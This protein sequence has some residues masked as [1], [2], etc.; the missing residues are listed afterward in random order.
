VTRIETD[1]AIIG[2]GPGGST[3]GAFIRK[4]NPK[5]RVSIFEREV[6]PRDH[7]GESQL[8][9]IGSILSELGVWD[10]IEQCGF[11]IKIGGTYR[12]GNS[13]DL[14]D[15]DFLPY[16]KFEDAP[17]PGKYEGQRTLTAFQVDRSI[18][19]KVLTDY[20]AELGCDIHFDFPIRKVETKGDAVTS[21]IGKDDV[22]IVAKYYVDATGHV[23][24]LRRALNVEV[25]EPS[26][27]KNIAVWDYWR[28][29][30]WAVSLGI[31]GT[32][33]QIL[34]LGYGWIWFIPIS[35][36][37]T[38]IGFVCP[39]DYYKKSGLS[40]EDLYA[41]AIGDEP[42]LRELISS[43][44]RENALATTKDW[45]FIAKRMSGPNWFLVG[46]SAGFADPI[47]S[48][49]LSLTHA[50]A[51]ELAFIILEAERG[52]NL[53]WMTGE[54]QRRNDRRIRQHIRF[55]DYWYSANSHFSDLKQYTSEIAKDAGLD[56]SAE[57]AF[58]W[59]G[60]GGFIE[61]DMGV[62][63]TALI[64][65]DQL[66]QISGKLSQEPAKSTLDG[67]NLFMLRLKD[68]EE[69]RIARFEDG[70]VRTI[71][72]FKKGERILPLHNLFGWV[73]QGLKHSPQLDKMM[74]YLAGEMT[75]AGY[76][77]DTKLQA[78]LCECLDA[79]IRD[80]WVTAKLTESAP[81]LR[82]EIP[83]E[84]AAIR[85]HVDE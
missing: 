18:Y 37:R 10:R 55:A 20:A 72:A 16:G 69:V 38:S 42:R 17:R 59:L 78:R 50:S 39:A 71:P 60:T 9:I 49:G 32:R 83:L 26:A 24:L 81:A 58:R 12:W 14:W 5:L 11:P 45:S 8:P 48:A 65:L 62:A 75:K 2:G 56:L 40:I 27:L 41:K 34:S 35:P 30:K 74:P 61:E 70:G 77:F 33:I 73:V 6:F 43:A 44:Q 25:E 13:Q 23:G 76:Q 19:D 4:H 57:E 66:H 22:E 3:T 67:F 80:G 21:L 29:A 52:G 36:D 47:L 63:G 53:N 15:F 84:T 31:G 1:V 82:H 28:D 51:K 7:I 54:Y 68:A 64:R 46:E 85:K 79:M